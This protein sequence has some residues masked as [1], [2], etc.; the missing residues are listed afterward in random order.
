MTPDRWAR[1]KDVFQAALARDRGARGAFLAEACADDD[2]LREEVESLLEAYESAGDF[3]LGV[4]TEGLGARNTAQGGARRCPRCD[5]RYSASEFLCPKDGEVL[6]EDEEALVG[7][8][9]DGLYQVER[10]IGRGGFGSVYLAH[11]ALL[12]DAVAVKVLRRDLTANPDFL[13]RFLREGRVARSI[14][15]PNLVTT[16]DLRVTSEGIAFMVMEYVEGR[17]LREVL[18]R[19]GRMMPERAVALLTPVASALDEAHA[20]GVVH[21]DLKPENIVVGD[22]AVKLL[23]LGLAKLRE[24]RAEESASTGL[25]LQGQWMGTP[26][27]M[28]PEQWGERPRDGSSDLDG[29]TDVYGLGVIAYELVTGRPPFVGGSPWD[30]RRRHVEERA[31]AVGDLAA[32]VPPSFGAAIARALSKDR[33]DRQA[34]PGAFVDELRRVLAEPPAV[35]RRTGRLALAGVAAAAVLAAVAAPLWNASTG[36]GGGEASV[37]APPPL[38]A[39]AQP[40]RAYLSMTDEDRIAFVD[41]RV[42]AV[43]RTIAG[44]EYVVPPAAREKI[45]QRVDRYAARV[46]GATPGREDLVS[47]VE[48]ARRYAPHLGPVF[49]EYGLP[50]LLGLYI[51]MIESEYRE[52]SVSSVGALGMFQ[53]LPQ[54]GARFGAS[55]EDLYDVDASAHTAAKYLA[56]ELSRFERDRMSVALS[57]AAYNWGATGIERY[58][59]DVKVLSEEEADLRFWELLN[60]RD[61]RYVNSVSDPN[62]VVQFFAA[63]VVGENPSA[64]GI[65]GGPLSADAAR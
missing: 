3:M 15:H 45:K 65:A 29:R 32:E 17:T 8:T 47:V 50:P 10:L 53:I 31:V 19:E 56:S 54:T 33:A 9:L 5:A 44:R 11:H 48:R 30:L 55:P 13:R 58:L 46:N 49:A 51:P 18:D 38:A 26:R 34:S 4:E 39:P 28:S 60:S 42:R 23:D 57:I 6:V 64:F 61:S 20:Q 62:Y 63:A 35:R 36:P 14:R 16:H 52:D 1:V 21:R 7:T 24:L 37:S 27:Y 2:A 22:G 12:R 41:D 59:D 25:T 43:S 40:A